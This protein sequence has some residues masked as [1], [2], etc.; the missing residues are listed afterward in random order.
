MGALLRKCRGAL[1]ISITWGSVWGAI[2][3]AIGLIVGLV[4]PDSIDPGEGP[5]VIVGTGAILGFVSG[6]G[7]GALL[8]LAEA[9]KRIPDL[10]LWRAA[11]WGALATAVYPLLT[12]ADD[13]MVFLLGP[14][15]AALAT[16]SVAVAKRAG[17]GAGSDGPKLPR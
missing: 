16:V 4:D 1:G 11:L 12:P 3:A 14:I 10:S 8:S 6:A 9:G 17:L 5:I 15:A 13:S 7:F 2:F